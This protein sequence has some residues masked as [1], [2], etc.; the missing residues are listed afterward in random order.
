MIETLT[1]DEVVRRTGLT[2]RALRFYEGRG[3]IRPL[4]TAAGRRLFGPGELE[5]VHRITA[6]KRAG[7]T[8]AQIGR[9]FDRKPVDIEGLLRVQ[10]ETL[11]AQAHDI[12]AVR[13]TIATALSRIERG[14]PLDAATLCSLIREGDRVVTDADKLAERWNAVTDRYYTPEEKARWAERMKAMPADFSQDEYNAKWK[15]LGDRIKAALPLDPASDAAQ[16][17]LGEWQALLA[18]F[19]AVA[20]P[21]MCAS[22]QRFYERMDEWKDDVDPGF[23]TA[24]FRFIQDASMAKRDQGAP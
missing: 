11:D 7:F 2:S 24:V 17:L 20:T 5:R 10:L 12:A 18:P 8:L 16:A 22:V 15:A 14:E 6:L 19:N 4:R 9:L 13:Q 1:I 21:D 3:L 23:D